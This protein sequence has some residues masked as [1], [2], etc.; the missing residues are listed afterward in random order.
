MCFSAG[1]SFT[2]AAT[3]SLVGI[4]TIRQMRIR[5]LY[6]F[7]MIPFLF[8]IQQGLEGGLWLLEQNNMHDLLQSILT[9]AYLTFVLMVWPLWI[10]FS[11]LMLEK[12]VSRRRVIQGLLIVGLGVALCL[13]I[14]LVWYGAYSDIIAHHVYYYF[15]MP[16]NINRFVMLL[17][18]CIPVVGPFLIVDDK[19]LRLWGL[20]LI[21]AIFLSMA[22]W[23]FWFTSV[24]CFF[25]ALLSIGVLWIVRKWK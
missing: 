6:P 11:L 1:A 8:A 13:G 9:Y 15:V 7:A 14:Y 5:S 19:R 12:Q 16:F 24:W 25:G 18:Y 23:M 4:F 3:L 20:L 17:L 10:P 22:I 21:L 2:A